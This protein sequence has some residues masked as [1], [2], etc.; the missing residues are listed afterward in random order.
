MS[1]LGIAEV[2]RC[3][4][5]TDDRISGE[6]ENCIVSI[7]PP[8]HGANWVRVASVS[9]PISSGTFQ[10]PRDE[11]SRIKLLRS[12]GVSKNLAYMT[13][14][15]Y[16]NGSSILFPETS[17]C[18][19]CQAVL[20]AN[21]FALSVEC[22]TE[23]GNITRW[24]N[25]DLVNSFTFLEDNRIF[26]V[27]KGDVIPAGNMWY[28]HTTMVVDG[29]NDMQYLVLPDIITD[30][31]VSFNPLRNST[32]NIACRIPNNSG[33]LYGAYANFQNQL[34]DDWSRIATSVITQI[35]VQLLNRN[36]QIQSLNGLPVYFVLEFK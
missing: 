1:L 23:F 4:I 31:R 5:D 32:Q 25:N 17:L 27:K 15:V 8:I 24:T 28:G 29:H 2:V 16:L 18:L 21:G 7:N 10:V 26:G 19:S 35:D 22:A 11:T 3:H 12:D 6:S 9:A 13:E 34:A 14:N 33:R 20:N 36:R 30:N